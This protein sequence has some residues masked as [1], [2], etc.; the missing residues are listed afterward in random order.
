V[1]SSLLREPGQVEARL[2]RF[3]GEYRWFLCRAEPCATETGNIVS[4]VPGTDTTRDR[5][6]GKTSYGGVNKSF[7]RMIDAIPNFADC[8]NLEG[9]PSPRINRRSTIPVSRWRPCGTVFFASWSIIRETVERLRSERQEAFSRGA[10]LRERAARAPE[11]RPVPLVHSSSTPS[12]WKW[13][14]AGMVRETATDIDVRKPGRNKACKCEPGPR[15][16]N[17]SLL[18]VRGDRRLFRVH[19]RV[20]LRWHCGR[21][22]T[23]PPLLRGRVQARSSS[24]GQFTRNSKRSSRAFIPWIGAAIPPTLIASELFGHTKGLSPARCSGGSGVSRRLTA[25]R[26]SSTKSANCA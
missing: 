10:S 16:E 5:R 8:W 25:E 7:G 14:G 4:S 23:L 6:G 9:T 21:R 24:P 11:G 2:R 26:S 3:D 17:R 15:D 19:R 13:T 20:S 1:C 22:W 12:G 18:D